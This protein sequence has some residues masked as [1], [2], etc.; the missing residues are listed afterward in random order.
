L[1]YYQALRIVKHNVPQTGRLFKGRCLLH[2]Y[3]K[4]RVIQVYK[5]ISGEKKYIKSK[6]YGIFLKAFYLIYNTC[7]LYIN[8]IKCFRT[9]YRRFC[10][11][12]TLAPLALNNLTNYSHFTDL[13]IL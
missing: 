4:M 10:Y 7:I 1:F 5:A 8:K 3:I 13:V 6:L 9:K 12:F 11:N 2:I